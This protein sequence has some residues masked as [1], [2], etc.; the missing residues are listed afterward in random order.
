MLLHA[1][2]HTQMLRIDCM[3]CK[4]VTTQTPPNTSNANRIGTETELQARA[5]RRHTCC[6][7]IVSVFLLIKTVTRCS[8]PM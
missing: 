7:V 3:L 4:R 8:Q 5:P 1:A 6:L 2:K